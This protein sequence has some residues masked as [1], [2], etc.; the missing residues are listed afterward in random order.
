MYVQRI[1]DGMNAGECYGKHSDELTGEAIVEIGYNVSEELA[2]FGTETF[3]GVGI[4]DNQNYE[5][6]TNLPHD[7]FNSFYC[8]PYG[9]VPP[10][11][12]HGYGHGLASTGPIQYDPGDVPYDQYTM[13]WLHYD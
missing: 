4:T 11:C 3:Y 12:P 2:N 10:T 6:M 7:Y 13:T 1:R 8:M 5:S 9:S